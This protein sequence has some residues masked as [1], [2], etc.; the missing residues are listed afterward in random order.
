[1]NHLVKLTVYGA[2][3]LCASCVQAPSSWETYE[4][5]QAAITRK[6]AASDQIMFTY[7]D[8]YTTAGM[9][10]DQK[11]IEQIKNDELL[12]PAVVMDDVLVDE[13]IIQ[14]KKIH[15]AILTKLHSNT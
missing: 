6:F 2:E 7:V 12:Y 1:M 4:W 3:Q 8:V 14:F 15:E 11:W 5:L 10:Q 9:D 13:G